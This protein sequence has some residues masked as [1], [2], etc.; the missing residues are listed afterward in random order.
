LIRLINVDAG[1]NG[2][3]VLRNLSLTLP[4]TG[5]VAILGPSGSGKTTLLRVLSSLLSPISGH[6][7]GIAGLRV[8]MVF[9]E[10]RLLPW[11]TALENVALPLRL[12]KKQAL[13]HAMQW[14]AYMDL[15]AFAHE[16]PRALSGGMQRRAAI[17]RACACPC[18]LLLLDEPFKGLDTALRL[19]VM[20]RVKTAAPLTVLV[21]HDREDAK[22]M[23]AGIVELAAPAI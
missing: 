18:G 2:Q 19:R 4:E 14:L 9:Q 5:V 7:E 8:S 12:P 6:I 22:L 20:T 21:T 13:A 11:Y 17:A 10:D 1:Y 3:P 16:Y 23:G 15:S